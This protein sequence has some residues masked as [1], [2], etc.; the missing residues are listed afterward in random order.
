MT[1]TRMT[2]GSIVGPSSVPFLEARNVTKEFGAVRALSEVNLVIEPGEIVALAGE[3]GSGKSTLAKIISGVLQ[4][5][6]GDVSVRGVRC[7]FGKPLDALGKGIALVSQEPTAAPAMTV[8]ENLLMSELRS[9]FKRIA[10]KALFEKAAPLLDLVGLDVDPRTPFYALR[11]GDRELA[12]VAK[13]LASKPQLLILDEATTRLPE[14]EVLLALVERLAADGMACLMITHRL[15]EIRRLAHRVVVLRDGRL[16][17]EIPVKQATDERVSTMMVGREL[18]EFFDKAQAE[19]GPVLLEVSDLAT[20]YA[21]AKRVSFQARAGEIVGLA[22]LVGSGR[23]EILET[24]AGAR[25]PAAGEVRVEGALL[26]HASPGTA[27]RAGIALVPEDRHNQ[28]LIM[29]ATV[30]DNLAIS[31]HKALGRSHRAADSERATRAIARFQ[32]RCTGPHALMS[33]LSGGSQQKVVFARCLE[34]QPR[35]LLLD[36]PTRGV[37]IGARAEIYHVIGEMANQ[38]KAVVI[39]SSDMVE[40]LGL[41]DRIIIMHEGAIAGVLRR[42]EAT[43]E[44]IALMSVGGGTDQPLEK[45]SAT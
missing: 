19:I 33:T 43:E 1:G 31:S 40:L 9:P 10:R 29:R 23:T 7:H 6:G 5:D 35:V 26:A 8:A 44:R 16:V 39:A 4:P 12:E 34:A 11:A 14:P 41:C 24:I 45:A 3:N 37:D 20:D 28:G 2:G 30:R 25:R 32:I 18:S 22:G 15:R 27:L 38:G 13:A 21:P 42:S 36:E 17:G